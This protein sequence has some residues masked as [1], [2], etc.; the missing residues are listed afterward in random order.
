M[1]GVG[2][3]IWRTAQSSGPAARLELQGRSAMITLTER[4]A[5]HVPELYRFD[6]G[7]I[8][9]AVDAAAPN[10]VAVDARGAGLL[11]QIA[12]AKAEGEALTFGGLVA[13]YASLQGFEAGKAWLDVHDFLSALARASILFDAPIARERYA[14]R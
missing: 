3:Q 4:T 7:G 5:L 10:W 12:T 1:S 11:R 6:E 2:G 14:G 9:Y 13:R 8:T